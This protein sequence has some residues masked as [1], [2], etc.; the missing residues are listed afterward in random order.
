MQVAARTLTPLKE[1]TPGRPWIADNTLQALRQAREAQAAMSENWKQLRN[2]AKRLARKDRVKWVHDQIQ[3]DPG[4]ISRKFGT[5][6][7]DNGRDSK[8]KG[9][10]CASMGNRSRGQAHTKLSGITWKQ[11]NGVLPIFPTTHYA[12]RRR[13]RPRI[14]E[15]EANEG[16]F[17]RAE[18]LTALAK[19]KKGKAP[20]P[21]E[22]VNEI[23]QL[24]D[25]DGEERLLRFYN[26]VW[27]TGLTPEQ[28]S[29]ATVVSIYKGKGD[30]TDP[31]SYRPI[32]LLNVT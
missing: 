27:D 8:A 6:Y 31:G 32:S 10:S 21:D 25:M 19:T 18:L 23:L 11:N 2:N 9:H 7:A 12:T 13:A 17:T 1:R 30:D 16:A 22:L 28:W 14:R 24:L 26:Q 29:H 4:G 15:A 5:W 3:S 20:G